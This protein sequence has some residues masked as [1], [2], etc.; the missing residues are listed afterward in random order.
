MEGNYIMKKLLKNSLLIGA[1]IL[2]IGSVGAGGIVTKAATTT[3]APETSTSTADLTPGTITLDSVPGGSTSTT[4]PGGID[5]GTVASSASDA[6]YKSTS[7]SSDLHVTNPGEP[8]GWSVSVADS[9]FSNATGGSLKGAVLSLADSKSPALT[10][11][12]TDNV[13]ALP[14]FNPTIALSTAPAT[15]VDAAAGDGV[16]AYT[17]TYNTGDASLMVPAG[18]V[19]G[20]YSSTLTWTL[21]N[22]PS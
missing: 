14:T 19:G 1:A 6:T 20:S 2:G 12:A 11:D 9:A 8:T 22:A 5:F 15:V 21:S 18:N 13:S 3:P 7:I 17:A 10:A 16:G 4:T